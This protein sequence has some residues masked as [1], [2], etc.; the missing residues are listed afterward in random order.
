MRILLLVNN[1]VGWQITKWLKEEGEQLVGLVVH[2]AEKRRYGDE[3][4]E[5]AEVRQEHVFNGSELQKP[6]VVNAI[7]ALQPDI[8]LSVL[9]GYILRPEFLLLFSEGVINVHL[10]YLPYN[11]G[12]YP[13]VWS[14]LD[15]TP[16][17]V[18]L[19]YVDSEIDTGDLIAQ[20]EI[21]IEPLDTGKTLYH[22]LERLCVAL[23]KEKWPLIRSGQVSR[24][25]QR[26]GGGTFHL[27]KNVEQIDHIDLDRTYTARKLINI[28]RARTFHPYP[29]AYFMH[30]GRKV[31]L[32]LQLL[33]EDRTSKGDGI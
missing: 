7:K 30:E 17:G 2:P 23:F 31:Y 14:I 18:T 29:G 32:R 1:W 28:I 33:L 24:V 6:G 16:A 13:N 21:P 19:H 15:G 4:I 9:F 11:R 20:Q 26:T 25:P 3:I 22:K 10:A 5:S 12:A 27:T 8:G